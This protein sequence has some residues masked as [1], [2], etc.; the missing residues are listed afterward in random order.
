MS[1]TGDLSTQD[2]TALLGRMTKV[3]E[4]MQQSQAS[5][6]Q[7][8]TTS[9]SSEQSKSFSNLTFE[10]FDESK[11]KFPSYKNRLENFLELKGI[12]QDD[13]Q[14]AKIL[15]Q[16][17]G[18][19]HYSILESLTA[20]ALPK[21]QTYAQLLKLLEDHLEPPPNVL[22]EQHR[23]YNRVQQ[24]NETIADYSAS[25]RTFTTTCK[26]TCTNCKKANN[27]EHLRRQF[28]RGIRDNSIREQLLRDSAEELTFQKA[29]DFALS[30][31][32]SKA[33]STEIAKQ[34][35]TAAGSNINKVTKQQGNKQSNKQQHNQQQSQGRSRN[36]SSS[37]PRSNN[38][39]RPRTHSRRRNTLDYKALG[40]DGLCLYCGRN[41]HLAR[42]CKIDFNKLYCKSCNKGG[43]VSKVCISTL[44]RKKNT[45]ESDNVSDH[46]DHSDNNTNYLEEYDS[47]FNN[48]ADIFDNCHNE[49]ADA[50]KFLA[51]V[52]IEGKPQQFEVDCGAGYTL[53]PKC[54]F[55]QLNV[56]CQLKPT[57]IRFRSYTQQIF[58]PLGV[59]SVNVKYKDIQSYEQMY[60]VRDDHV[61]LLGRTW[62]RH[63]NVNLHDLDRNKQNVQ[64]VNINNIDSVTQPFSDIF[65]PVIGTLPES[66]KCKLK[67]KPTAN[68]VFIKQRE[69]PFALREQVDRELD[70]LEQQNIITRTSHSEWG[71]PLVVVPK[72][73]G[74]VRLC[75]DYKVA[76]NPQLE[77]EHYPIPRIDEILN[78]LRDST[79]FCTLDLYKAYLHVPVD[80]DT[81]HIQTISTHRGTYRMNRLSFGI[82]S[83]PST[84]NR[85]MD[86]ILNGLHGVSKY[87]DDIVI[88]A[89]TLEQCRERLIA[90]LKRLREYNLH[91]NKQ[92][93]TFFQE[94]ISYVG[95]VIE[96]NKI[97][98]DPEKTKAILNAPRPK[99]VV[100]VRRLLGMV[101]YYSRFIHD[102]ST[103]TDPIR[104]LL[105]NNVPFRWTAQCEAAFIKIKNA[106]AGDTV[107]TPFNPERP[108]TL[109]TDASPVGIAAI[110]SHT[111]D[112][113][114]RPI[115][116]ISRS[117][118][119]AEQHYSQLDREALAIAWAI[120]KLHMYLMGRKFT[121]ITDNRPLT[122]IF[123]HDAKLPSI[124]A[125]RLLRYAT[126][127]SGFSY[128]VCHRS[129]EKHCNVDYLSRAPLA[130]DESLHSSDEIS[131]SYAQLVHTIS[132][133][134]INSETIAAETGNDPE[135]SK[136]RSDLLTGKNNEPEYS[137][138][139]G[140]V[141]RG[142]RVFIPSKLREALLDELHYTHLGIVKMKQLAR[143]HIYWPKI[144]TDIERK[145]HACPEC[146]RTQNNPPKVKQHYWEI[147][148]QNFQRIHIDYAGLFQDHY[149]LILVDARSKWPEVRILKKAPTSES[150]IDLLED[151]FSTHGFPEVLVSDNATIFTSEEFK[152]YCA[153]N[154]IF[155]KFSAPNHP[156]TNGLAERYVQILKR[157][158]QAMVNDPLPLRRKVNNILF[159]FRAT[160]L[161][162]G[163]SPAELYLN[164]K[165]RTKL[166]AIRPPNKR[167]ANNNSNMRLTS[168]RDLAVGDRVLSRAYNSAGKT[169]WKNGTIREKL[170]RLHYQ[171]EQDD[172]YI[173]KR[174]IDQ[175]RKSLVEKSRV[176]P[177]HVSFDIGPT[178]GP[179]HNQ[180]DQHSANSEEPN[181][182]QQQS[183]DPA[184]ASPTPEQPAPRRSERIRTLPR[185][186][187]DY[188]PR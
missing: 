15:I 156:A 39:F 177:K 178:H 164:R 168:G 5:G 45:R 106:I 142:N 155:Q 62:I 148:E 42:D 63:L 27:E 101:T 117:L 55:D 158:L 175:L 173:L 144:D 68:P 23:F 145:V 25:L 26:F 12:R 139:Q 98:K 36:R 61:P 10:P 30:I 103:I 82:K 92:K 49:D 94:K 174:H 71:S 163:K 188:V 118:T 149:Y 60:I 21:T 109:A 51:T 143:Q 115:L 159:R 182:S 89:P 122:R 165:I 53:L 124:T 88:Y 65:A 123:K 50:E 95:Y 57:N 6:S 141:F 169:Y 133:I 185:K 113:Q 43:H 52:L 47:S 64:T 22:V 69:V 35:P 126:F 38:N 77:Q 58:V 125:S 137:L 24:Q 46:D 134:Q 80:D 172:G 37:Q 8:Q 86:Q 81:A 99:D 32:A 19:K 146:A 152:Q 17:I 136:L 171:V 34:Q 56:R 121:L 108:V 78:Q 48:I 157:K 170:G 97:S 102:I 40:I 100:G 110:L 44:Q 87:F 28:I 111:I 4:T 93:C 79:Y 67:L 166:D 59:V 76:I 2:L 75:V 41:N 129:A 130:I 187:Q 120:N 181:S 162:S 186:L 131:D 154:G 140:I 147:P 1:E 112:G 167:T 119:K 54:Q 135:L 66:F 85:I 127:L 16:C 31:V 153:T 13:T 116:F 151:I 132:T 183:L 104:Q 33:D 20:P 161:S 72:P 74:T 128:T 70:S 14:C 83:A 179:S 91:L 11:E 107:L 138:D 150:T 160:P 90:C 96:K 18:A 180:G 7:K 3:L 114:E 9:S 105:Q 176:P 184:P 84:F 29:V 73:D